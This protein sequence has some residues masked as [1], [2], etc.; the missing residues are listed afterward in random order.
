M[1][2]PGVST[3]CMQADRMVAMHLHTALLWDTIPVWQ[4]SFVSEFDS[5]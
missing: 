4:T 1:D 3:E 5:L 2:M